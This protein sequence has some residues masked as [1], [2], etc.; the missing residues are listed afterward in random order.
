MEDRGPTTFSALASNLWLPQ[1]RM[2]C[3][4]F[5]HESTCLCVGGIIRGDAVV[6]SDTVAADKCLVGTEGLQHEICK[7][8][9]DG[10]LAEI[11]QTAQNMNRIVGGRHGYGDLPQIN[12]S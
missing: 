5:D 9:S 12:G 1:T 8:I 10:M 4:M 11:R 6:R 2:D 7:G 3:D